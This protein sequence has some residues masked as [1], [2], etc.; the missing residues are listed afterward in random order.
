MNVLREKLSESPSPGDMSCY[1]GGRRGMLILDLI[2][3]DFIL[4]ESHEAPASEC[5]CQAT[6]WVWLGFHDLS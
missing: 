4:S 6:S 5:I 1:S 3:I 2:L